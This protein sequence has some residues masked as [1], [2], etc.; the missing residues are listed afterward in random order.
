MNDEPEGSVPAAAWIYPTL[1][2][3][4]LGLTLFSR[5]LVGGP[6]VAR[7]VEEWKLVRPPPTKAFLDL[8]AWMQP[9]PF[10]LAVALPALWAVD[11]VA[12][13]LLGGWARFEGRLWFWIVLGGLL[14]TW[15]LMEVSFF[16][17]YYK[18][19]RGLSR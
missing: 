17:P 5:I 19:Q 18:L 3:G 13:W 15:G 9:L 2:H 7:F 14:I 11:G 16:L 12:L 8:S 4:V 1:I 6:A 10:A